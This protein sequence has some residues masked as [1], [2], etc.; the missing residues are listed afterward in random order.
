[1]KAYPERNGAVNPWK[2][3]KETEQIKKYLKKAYDEWK[4]AITITGE[5]AAKEDAAKEE[6]S[7]E[8][9]SAVDEFEGS[10]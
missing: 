2:H 10:Q 6:D 9:D 7:A 4:D 3:I 1:M 8:E 5:D